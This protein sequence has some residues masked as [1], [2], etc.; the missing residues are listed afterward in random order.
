[1]HWTVAGQALAEAL[2]SDSCAGC[3]LL[4]HQAGITVTPGDTNAFLLGGVG[5]QLYTA[6]ASV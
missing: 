5:V 3:H 6:A 1:M 4:W 2:S